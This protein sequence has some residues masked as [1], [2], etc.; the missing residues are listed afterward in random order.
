MLSSAWIA[1]AGLSPAYAQAESAGE[2]NPSVA[3]VGDIIVTATRRAQSL[4]DV[5]V[6]VSAIGGEQLAR[7]GATDIRQLNQISPSLNV[8]LAT[9][10]GSTTARIRNI[11][12]NGEN[13]GLES[14]VA[15]FIDGVYRSRSGSGMNDLGE[16]ERIEVLRGPQGTL[17]GRNS[18]AG[19]ISVF[20]KK[21]QFE[22]GGMAEATYGNYDYLR[23]AGA[24]T[25]PIVENVLAGRIDAVF[26]KRG[27]TITDIDGERDYNNRDRYLVRGQ[28]LFEPNDDLS[29]RLIGDYSK[30]DER[31]CAATVKS[32]VVNLSRNASGDVVSGPNSIFGILRDLG[33]DVPL[34][35]PYGRVTAVTPGRTFATKA[36][37]WGVSGEVNWDFGV[38]NLTSITAY[39]EW[40]VSQSPDVDFG[41]LDIA[42]RDDYSRKFETFTQ[43][44]RLQG[45]AFGDR[46]DWLVGAYY[47]NET[48]NLHDEFRF[49]AD[50]EKFLNCVV[51]RSGPLAG[52][53]N[54][55]QPTCSNAPAAVFPG[56]QGFAAAL[57]APR[58]P[59]TGSNED[60]FTQKSKSYAFF[61]HEIFD[62]TDR[63][64]LTMGLRYTNETK[65]LTASLD[66]NNELCTA[67]RAA[68]INAP[69]T[70]AGNAQASTFMSLSRAACLVNAAVDGSYSGD[71]GEGEWSGTAVLS[72][73]F[74]DDLMGYASYSRGYK[75][76]GFNLDRNALDAP[77]R[78]I[79]ALN[80]AGVPVARLAPNDP[81]APANTP[82]NGI[83][84][85]ADLAFQPETV[86]AYEIG[87]KLST[88]Q[89]M[90]N[91]A[92]FYQAFSGFQSNIF[93]G[94]RFT[95]T[96]ING[97]KGALEGSNTDLSDAT[98]S[99]SSGLK[100][101]VISKGIELDALMRPL[102]DLTFG[103]GFTYASAKFDKNAVGTDGRP[104]PSVLFQIP[105][106]QLSISPEYV[107]TGSASWQPELGSSGM[108]GLVYVDFRYQSETNTGT[109]NDLE[110]IQQGFATMNGRLGLYTADQRWG[111]E[112][113]AQN[114]LNEK[115]TQTIADA[116]L[117]GSG[118]I[119]AVQ[120][121]L[122]PTSTQMFI[123]FPADPRMFGL[124]VRARF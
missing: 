58:L 67:L 44:L 76:G 7:S 17:S 109:D 50:S 21:P 113:W 97:C 55:A 5:P 24:V 60:L 62:I 71:K 93:D 57:G 75:A 61:T 114:L 35:D 12:T 84:E 85:V 112:L 52:T 15:L 18:S 70:P 74:T 92:A 27:G 19:L 77:G 80:A 3:N 66:A 40:S 8:S 103:A 121:G 33:A 81:N 22:F 78:V 53:Y 26:Q 2:P 104:L 110:K 106:Q 72:Y 88:P 42:Y 56:Y 10:E 11:G 101:G 47:A 30:K 96:S 23:L 108:N 32:P 90:L 87:L 45:K 14:A 91:M 34:G 83:P 69:M 89:F 122:S 63:L 79:M 37:D 13:P 119:R 38:A 9:G 111:I 86:D 39:R 65:D 105:G 43:E 98:G 31:C 25:G 16:I 41:Q 99:C 54:A 1:L 59:G 115:F 124:T 49:G 51:V 118:T 73:R 4:S 116:P 107:V 95:V 102:P 48:L 20:T 64:S 68:S 36:K 123:A 29:V 120:Q 117:Q 46:L 94:T 82:G 100:P 28:L 6:A